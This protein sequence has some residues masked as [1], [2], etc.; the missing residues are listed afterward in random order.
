M[1]RIVNL[2]KTRKRR[3]AVKKRAQ[4]DANAMKF[5][6]TKAERVL[7]ATQNERARIKLDGH[8]FDDE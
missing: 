8:R 6:K 3:E 2:N 7:N 5:G 1:T 4:A